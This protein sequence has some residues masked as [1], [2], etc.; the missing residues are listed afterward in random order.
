MHAMIAGE[1][2]RCLPLPVGGPPTGG[3]G[4]IDRMPKQRISKCRRC[5][6]SGDVGRLSKKGYC[7]P[8]GE[9]RMLENMRAMQ[10]KQG[11]EYERWLVSWT[12]A[13]VAA[14]AAVVDVDAAL[15]RGGTNDGSAAPPQP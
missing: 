10:D 13:G 1:Y 2:H 12:A 9:V 15:N 6:L 5:G 3:R 4:I 14:Y 11:P 7:Y 8:C